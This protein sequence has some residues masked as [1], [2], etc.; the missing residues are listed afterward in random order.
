MAHT[1]TF[2]PAT[3]TVPFEGSA[4]EAL[5]THNVTDDVM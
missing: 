5:V 4:A 2:L 1:S 3:V